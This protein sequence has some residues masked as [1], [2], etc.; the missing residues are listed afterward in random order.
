[1]LGKDLVKMERGADAAM[2]QGAEEDGANPR[3]TTFHAAVSHFVAKCVCVCVLL[4]FGLC[5][6]VCRVVC[7]VLC[8]GL[9]CIC[10]CGC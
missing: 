5:C 1:M 9:C 3:E 7:C 8:F 6:L 2:T 10:A 4:C